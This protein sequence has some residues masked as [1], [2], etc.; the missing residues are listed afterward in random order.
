MHGIDGTTGDQFGHI[1]GELA[2]YAGE[3][4]GHFTGEPEKLSPESHDTPESDCLALQSWLDFQ[5]TL[6]IMEIPSEVGGPDRERLYYALFALHTALPFNEAE[7]EWLSQMNTRL[8]KHSASERPKLIE[9]H[10]DH[11]MVA[12]VRQ[13]VSGRSL[14]R[15]WVLWRRESADFEGQGSLAQAREALQSLQEL[16][17]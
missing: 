2:Y 4:A 3:L 17:S 9:A 10:E 12:G 14:M 15:R 13:I 6:P 16:L 1:G 8:T 5:G 11:I 7:R